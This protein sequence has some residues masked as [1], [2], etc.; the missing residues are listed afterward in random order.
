M[1]QKVTTI[2]IFGRYEMTCQPAPEPADTELNSLESYFK[3][4]EFLRKKLI[5][6]NL[7]DQKHSHLA[8]QNWLEKFPKP[9]NSK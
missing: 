4:D 7:L 8:I 5:N 2:K 3:V 6:G 1:S 9:L